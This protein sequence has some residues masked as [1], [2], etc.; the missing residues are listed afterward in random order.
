MTTKDRI[1]DTEEAWDSGELGRSEEFV[2]VAPEDDTQIIEEALCLRPISIRLEQSLINDFKKIAELNGL[3]YQPLMRQAL[4]RFADHEKR[5][6]LNQLV[7]Q[8][9]HDTEERENEAL[10]VEAQKVA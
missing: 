9:K 8:R 6:I 5:R 4:R 2:A 3:A 10:G 1:L 7:A